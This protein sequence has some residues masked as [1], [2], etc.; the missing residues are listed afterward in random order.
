M[1]NIRCG[2]QSINMIYRVDVDNIV[3][4]HRQFNWGCDNQVVQ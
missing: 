4:E 2:Y 1:G 3:G